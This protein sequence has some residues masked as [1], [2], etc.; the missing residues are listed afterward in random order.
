MLKKQLNKDLEKLLKEEDPKILQ[1]LA[2]EDRVIW[3]SLH[4]RTEKGHPLDFYNHQYLIDVY[5]DDSKEIVVQKSAQTGLTTYGVNRALHFCDTNQ[6]A[7]IYTFPTSG[8]VSEFSKARVN[9]IIKGS[10]YLNSRVDDIDSVELKQFAGSFIYFRGTWSERQAI[11]IPADMLVHDE[12]DRSKPEI[13]SMYRE[14]LSHSDY[15]YVIHLSNPSVPDYGINALY[16]RSD[17]KKWFVTCPECGK[18]QVLTFPDSIKMGVAYKDD[19]YY[20][21]LF[22]DARFDDDV[23]RRGEWRETNPGSRLSGYHISQLMSP[24]ISAEE[25]VNKYENERWKQTFFNFVL[26]EPYAGENIPLKRTD[27]LECVQNNH[28]MWEEAEPGVRTYMGVDQGDEI[29][30]TVWRSLRGA[31]MLLR[32]FTVTDFSELANAMDTYK[33]ASCVIDAL[34][35][36]HS[37]R[38][39]ALQFPGRVWLC[40]YSDTQK[41]VITW[42][43]DMDSREYSVTANRT[44]TLDFLADE[45]KR[46]HIILPKLTNDLEEFIRHHAALVKE[47]V[48]KSDG[49]FR[50]AYMNTAPDHY[51]HASNYAM[52]ALSR[53]TAGSLAEMDN[54]PK[55]RDKPITSGLLDRKF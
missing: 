23:R 27:M 19:I 49:T 5:D 45:Y 24:W 1:A 12:T 10:E 48:E 35:N 4:C 52:I 22:C 3:A 41:K 21:C 17:M 43:E 16:M 39:F 53:A 31:V 46:K 6:V 28:T 2:V 50:Y 42:N 9:P 13:I 14:R 20:K 34:P 7:V 26:G 54:K 33:V 11:S 29:H 36:K 44:E 18:K 55:D 38:D 47:K 15:K 37:A 25:I 40:Y 30:V 32:A 8:D 51:A